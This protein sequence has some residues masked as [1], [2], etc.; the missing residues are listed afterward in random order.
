MPESDKAA[1]VRILVHAPTGR[2]ASATAEVLVRAGLKAKICLDLGSLVEEAG[3]GAAAVFIA[4]E[5]LFGQD[6][7]PLGAWVED[8][9][10]WSDLPFVLLTSRQDQ[11]SVAAW[12]Q[13]VIG[14]LR[15]VSLL[16]RPVQA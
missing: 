3:F 11:P 14:L 16:E 7:A 13:R 1:E 12:R 15:N 8:Q 9:P 6:L 10:A 4:E 5:A 2:D